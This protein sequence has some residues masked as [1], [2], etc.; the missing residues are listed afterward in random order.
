MTLFLLAIIFIGIF[1]LFIVVLLKRTSKIN[2]K[3]SFTKLK[4]NFNS[5]LQLPIK[6]WLGRIQNITYNNQ[7]FQDVFLVYKNEYNNIIKK[8][9]EIIKV[10]IDKLEEQRFNLESEIFQEEITK[11]AY[12]INLFEDKIYY[13]WNK[14]K[15][16]LKLEDIFYSEISQYKTI[17]HN[18]KKEFTLKEKILTNQGKTIKKSIDEIEK[19]FISF[20]T[21]IKKAQYMKVKKII[22][23]IQ[24]ELETLIF[25]LSIDI[26]QKLF[27]EDR[28][29]KIISHIEKTFNEKKLKNPNLQIDKIFKKVPLL[30][31]QI[32]E[33]KKQLKESKFLKNKVLIEKILNDLHKVYSEIEKEDQAFEFVEKRFK[34]LMKL[35]YQTFDNIN[36]V[37]SIFKDLMENVDLS[38]Q[39]VLLFAKIKK[40]KELFHL[41]YNSVLLLFKKSDDKREIYKHLKLLHKQ[42]IEVGLIVA[43]AFSVVMKRD[44]FITNCF[45]EFKKQKL[46]ITNLNHQIKNIAN[47][48][49]KAYQ[50]NLKNTAI[51][52]DEVEEL[53]KAKNPYFKLIN[54]KLK[55]SQ[56]IINS[57]QDLFDLSSTKVETQKKAIMFLNR[58]RFKSKKI[59]DNLKKIEAL[60]KNKE[61]NKSSELI[62]ECLELDIIQ[63]WKE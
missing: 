63:K 12:Q 17:F 38:N 9:Q 47:N 46:I 48:D 4:N 57:V 53:L 11:L 31:K 42:A 50:K 3:N 41:K 14:L 7:Q 60:F 59:D 25:N 8:Y 32:I 23:E 55:Q 29:P 56:T 22:K 5:L 34:E 19:L 39:E 1:L 61:Y 24:Q 33:I 30:Q 58:F 37:A 54:D 15:Q 44:D 45:Q 26:N 28:I 27:L 10:K 20:E 16:F 2:N 36:F 18:I 49:L 13:F 40:E 6:S 62:K 52:L 35:Y 21:E 43:E 51:I